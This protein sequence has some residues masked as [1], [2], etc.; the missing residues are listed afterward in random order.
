M[1]QPGSSTTPLY[2]CAFAQKFTGKERDTES[3]LDYFGARYYA[4]SMGRWMSPDWSKTPQAVPYADLKNP[5]SLNLYGYVDNNPLS[6]TDE[7]G[8]CTAGTETHG[9][10]W[11]FFHDHGLFGVETAAEHQADQIKEARG[12]IA[13]NHWDVISVNGHWQ[14]SS[15]SSDGDVASWW[16][17]YNSAYQKDI[18]SGMTAAAAMG[19]VSGRGGEGQPLTGP[20]ARDLAKYNGMEPVKDAP[21]DSHGQPVFRKDGKFYTPD[22]D[23][24]NGGVWKE[25]NRQG[26]RTGTFNYDLSSKI[27]K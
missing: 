17:D 27:G 6:K 21:F 22:V 25:F 18:G 5:Q 26:Q 3:G 8:H 19:L 23:G 2:V 15:V 4:S 16:K 11:C 20:Q 12:A 13:A 10:V 9:A 14:P 7:D 1:M 24:H